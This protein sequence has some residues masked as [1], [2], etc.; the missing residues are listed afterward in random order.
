MVGAAEQ[1]EGTGGVEA[2]VDGVDDAE[3]ATEVA[4]EE[5]PEEGAREAERAEAVQKGG[6]RAAANRAAILVA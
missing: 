4:P 5:R 6:G 2:E 3:E 1:M